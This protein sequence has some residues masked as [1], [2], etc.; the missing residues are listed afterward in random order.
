MGIL[1]KKGDSPLLAGLGSIF[2]SLS[3]SSFSSLLFA[4]SVLK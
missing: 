2:E 1:A 3:G 4:K